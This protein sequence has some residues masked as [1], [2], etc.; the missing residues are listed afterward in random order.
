MKSSIQALIRS[1]NGYFYETAGMLFGFFNDPTQ[2]HTCASK[3]MEATGQ[4]VEVYGCQ[5][6]AAL[7][8]LPRYRLEVE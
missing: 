7:Q 8:P 3:I 1:S 6:S 2:A 5:L 4:A